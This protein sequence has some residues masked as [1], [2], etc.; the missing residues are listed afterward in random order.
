MLFHSA[1]HNSTI[2]LCNNPGP[3]NRPGNCRFR[4]IP[5]ILWKQ[6]SGRIFSDDFRP[7]PTGKHRKLEGIH[8]K[9]S[10]SFSAG[11]LLP[12]SSDYRCF[13]SGYGDFP[14]SFL[15][16]LAISGRRNLRPENHTMPH[17]LALFFSTLQAFKMLSKPETLF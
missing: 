15:Q 14:T 1:S 17:K 4:I 5:V 7:I 10:G 16:D 11:I 13:L 3:T 6:Y 12:Y 2:Y 8:R 9:K